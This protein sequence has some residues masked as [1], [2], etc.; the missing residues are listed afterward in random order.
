MDPA[1]KP[2]LVNVL[3]TLLTDVFTA[4]YE[5]ATHQKLARAFGYADGYMR[6]LL[7]AGVA[8]KEELIGIVI[9]ERRRKFDEAA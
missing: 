4:Q 9:E 1:H 8:H 6:A 7:E 3:R 2:E 5:G